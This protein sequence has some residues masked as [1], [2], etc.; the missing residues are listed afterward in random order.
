MAKPPVLTPELIDAGVS[1]NASEYNARVAALR[2]LHSESAYNPP[3]DPATLSKTALEAER[4]AVG[5]RAMA[6]YAQE[7]V[8]GGDVRAAGRD[9][10]AEAQS[11]GKGGRHGKAGVEE[12][13]SVEGGEG[14]VRVQARPSPFGLPQGPKGQ[15][16][17]ASSGNRDVN[18]WTEQTW[19]AES[20]EAVRV[21]VPEG[22]KA[23]EVRKVFKA[24]ALVKQG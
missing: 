11:K 7:G 3:I 22:A 15:E 5:G 6:V 14:D 19:E 8:I 4:G 17:Q 23:V 12:S 9:P 21:L 18:V 16:P 13:E 24:T 10:Q 2:A 1:K 20:E